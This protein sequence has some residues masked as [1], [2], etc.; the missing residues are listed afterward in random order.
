[1]SVLATQRE[2]NIRVEGSMSGQIAVGEHIL[3]IGSV[4]G[5]S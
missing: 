2:V 3:Q 4:H 1:M 5:G